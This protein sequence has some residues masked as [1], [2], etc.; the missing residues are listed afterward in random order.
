L[1][2]DAWRAGLADHE[3][4]ELLPALEQ[5]LAWMVDYGDADG[6]GFLEY[7][8]SSGRGLVNQG[9]KDSADGIRFRDGRIAEGPIALC[10]VQATRT[11]RRWAE[12]RCSKP[13]GASVP[14]STGCGPRTWR[15]GF[16]HGF[17]VGTVM[18]AIR[19]LPWMVRNGRPIP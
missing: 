19:Q 13:S 2:H 7:Q 10:E 3:V 14:I 17:G 8:D 11:R 1:L 16:E 12:L 4:I 15:L 18:V 9:W 5:A 6:D